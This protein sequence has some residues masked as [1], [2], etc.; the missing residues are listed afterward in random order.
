MFHSTNSRMFS[1]N[2][3][4]ASFN[5]INIWR[6]MQMILS[7]L[8]LPDFVIQCFLS[9]LYWCSLTT[10]AQ[11]IPYHGKPLIRD[12]CNNSGSCTIVRPHLNIAAKNISSSCFMQVSMWHSAV[13]FQALS[14]FTSTSWYWQDSNSQPL[15][16][17]AS[18]TSIEQT[19]LH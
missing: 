11:D 10:M 19:W 9:T 2:N 6:K 17:Q 13:T 7:A 16:P 18:V 8:H 1:A 14:I 5:H 15:A 4:R 12:C 3:N